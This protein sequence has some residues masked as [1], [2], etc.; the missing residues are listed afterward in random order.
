MGPSVPIDG[1]THLVSMIGSPVSHS[2]SPATH[3]LA[4]KKMGINAVF[5]VFD[6]QVE[7]LPK[8]MAAFR[9][10]KGW[11]STT[12]TMP[13]KQ[14]IIPYLDALSPTA[15]LAGAVNV[16]KKEADGRVVGYNADGPGFI[17]NLVKN[18]VVVKGSTITLLGPGGAGSA[19]LAQASLDGAKKINVFARKGGRSYE[20]AFKLKERIENATACRIN[21]CAFEDTDALRSSIEESD[22]LANC[23]NVGMGQGNTDMP[24]DPA[25][26]KP[27]MVVADVINTPRE[28]QLL[29]EAKKRGCKTYGGLGMVD[30]QAVVADRIRFGIDIPIREIRAELADAQR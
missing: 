17:N 10:M 8:V 29:K 5:L 23:T 12:V 13:C 21:I 19:I 15:E 18:G 24:I 4:Y 26:I 2:V 28:T 30:Q 14:A 1:H 20:N 7:D 11:D 16:V 27:G 22:I 3:S 25:L 6:I 9:V